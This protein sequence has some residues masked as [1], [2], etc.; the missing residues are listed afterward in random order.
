[1]KTR[2]ILLLLI[3]LLSAAACITLTSCYEELT[4]VSVELLQ[5]EGAEIN[6]Y[7]T[8]I[9]VDSGTY[10]INFKDTV[11]CVDRYEWKL[12]NEYGHEQSSK[13]AALMNDGYNSFIIKLFYQGTETKHVYT[14]NVFRN[15][16]AEIRYYD[17]NNELIYTEKA[18]TNSP[19]SVNMSNIPIK[20]GYDFIGWT[21]CAGNTV[22]SIIPTISYIRLY[23]KYLP[24]NYDF[25]LDVNG[26][27]PL[28][29]NA[30][31][32][33]FNQHYKLPVPTREGY[34]FV[35]WEDEH[36][37]AYTDEN[38]NSLNTWSYFF[39]PQLIAKW[40]AKSYNV[41]VDCDETCGSVTGSGEY[42]YGSQVTVTANA[43]S[44]YTWLG[45][46]DGDTMVSADAQY[47]F[48]MPSHDVSL[49]AKWDAYQFVVN[50]H[51]E[52]E[53]P[54]VIATLTAVSGQSVS[55]TRSQRNPVSTDRS[56]TLFVWQGWYEAGR[57]LTTENVYQTVMPNRNV[58]VAERWTKITI[59][60]DA[61]TTTFALSHDCLTVGENLTVTATSENNAVN[62][63]DWSKDGQHY[64]KGASFSLTA[65]DANVTV[66]GT[67]TGYR[68]FFKET[69]PDNNISFAVRLNGND[70][71]YN[72]NDGSYL[73]IN[74]G[75]TV[76][77][78][79][80]CAD[81][82]V[83]GGGHMYL[84]KGWKKDG[85]LLTSEYEYTF[86][87]PASSVT[88]EGDAV[89]CNWEYGCNVADIPL[90]QFSV[91]CGLQKYG[92]QATLIA[93]SVD[94]YQFVS[95][96]VYVDNATT[97]SFLTDSLTLYLRFVPQN[98]R[99]V[100]EYRKIN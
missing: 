73:G 28:S 56:V 57:L 78:N 61:A 41:T 93:P 68:L 88:L 59:E 94:G 18:M 46:Y 81:L 86:T 75:D 42:E 76:S 95:W 99:Y 10:S 50:Q 35:Y 49:S 24:K 96:S 67:Y 40:S 38:G 69:A 12:Y 32:V 62:Y 64:A 6:D 14:V 90:S 13:T 34:D 23:P 30:I 22:T 53:A 91:P 52:G 27:E 45:W 74:V 26:G 4:D 20:S 80:K 36:G 84:W 87:M 31:S 37:N 39:N 44:D 43:N 48:T 47:T 7:S 83:Y 19:Y 2:K 79:V 60:T 100:A 77:V 17:A 16:Y 89:Y 58:T 11:T 1:M 97:P 70:F 85:Q 9:V 33:T 51:D 98:G 66:Y 55:V 82:S 72:A 15:F 92:E 65:T 8:E 63:I 25:T 21:N 3:V 54:R 29:S 71:E 5:I